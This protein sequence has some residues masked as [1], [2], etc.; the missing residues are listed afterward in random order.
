MDL[1]H[2][3][4]I[5]GLRALAV[6]PIV[7]F[8]A[9]VRQ[10]Q[11]GFI[12]VDIFFVISGFLITGIIIRD[13]DER[14]FSFVEFYRRRV[15]RIIPA[16]VAMLVVTMIVGGIILL[17]LELDRLRDSTVAAA[18]FASN[19][20]FW[21]TTEY[22]GSAAET[23]PLLHTWS[24]GAEEQFYIFYPLGLVI[25]RRFAPERTTLVLAILAALS[26]LLDLRWGLRGSVSGFY[27]LPGRM[28]ELLIGGLLAVHGPLQMSQRT[29]TALSA[30]GLGLIAAGLLVIRADSLF[31]APM[32]LLPCIG[33]ALLIACS[34][35]TRVGAALS[36]PAVRWIGLIS[37][38]LY[39]WHWPI[40]A[41][42]RLQWGLHL[43]LLLVVGTVA[44]SVAAGAA[45]YYLVENPWRRL[46]RRH[47]P[48]KVVIGG[49]G[50]LAATCLVIIAVPRI[51]RAVFPLDP[52]IARVAE[53]SNYYRTAT[54]KAQQRPGLCFATAENQ[55]FDAGTCLALAKDRPNIL[56][57]GDSHAAQYWL[58]LARRFPKANILQATSSG[59]FPQFD[60]TGAPWCPPIMNAGLNLAESGRVSGVIIAA[61]WT[62][63]NVE[64]LVQAV[65]RLSARGVRVAVIGPVNEYD[66][67]FSELLARALILGDVGR[68]AALRSAGPQQLDRSMAK[69]V[70]AAGGDYYSVIDQECPRGSCKLYDRNGEPFHTDYGHV[71]EAAAE[72]LLANLPAF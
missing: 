56:L 68:M 39:L 44:A 23:M 22:F 11:G 59:C 60:A 55:R 20:Y 48:G 18:A 72:E 52:K 16:L 45:S 67:G 4:E 53:H 61:R 43:P 10:I 8:H 26:F 6:A 37:Y 70:R 38:S 36:L 35:G 5:D 28:W 65:R 15:A 40:M 33:A 32:A 27:L 9:G 3:D 25:L 12:G 31:P 49:L 54:Y 34:H 71:G 13:V 50:A 29:K 17:P 2:R 47:R 62:P 58:P 14:R 46:A 42:A 30:L 57:I 1:K 21:K 63:E 19:I 41:F 51:T 66:G 7:L 24:L 64:P 69:A